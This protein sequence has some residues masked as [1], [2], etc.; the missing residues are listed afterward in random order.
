MLLINY[1][2]NILALAAYIKTLP[3]LQQ[4]AGMQLLRP[5]LR[6]VHVATLE[7]EI[8]GLEA[9]FIK[10]IPHHKTDTHVK[11]RKHGRSR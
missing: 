11:N 4:Q 2:K 3:T 6:A 1:S 5:L 7:K 9:L 8:A 10:N